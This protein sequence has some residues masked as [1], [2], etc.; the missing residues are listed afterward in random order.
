M[1]LL[2]IEYEC[3]R[4]PFSGLDPRNQGGA[5]GRTSRSLPV[6]CGSATS[7]FPTRVLLSEASG[8][9]WSAALLICTH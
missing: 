5:A 4:G 1:W 9:A 2:E 6:L 8:L 7:C 3:R